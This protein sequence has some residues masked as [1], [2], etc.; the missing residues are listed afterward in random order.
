[1]CIA[2]IFVYVHIASVDCCGHPILSLL[3]IAYFSFSNHRPTS[4]LGTCD[5][6]PGQNNVDCKISEKVDSSAA[7]V[8]LRFVF[9]FVGHFCVHSRGGL[10]RSEHQSFIILDCISS[11][12]VWAGGLC[13]SPLLSRV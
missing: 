2:Q 10:L 12:G 11:W 5:Q 13:I 7:C 4:K 3:F 1:M 8:K 6:L 9:W